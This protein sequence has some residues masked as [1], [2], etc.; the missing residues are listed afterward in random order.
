MDMTYT[1]RCACGAVSATITGEPARVGQCWC[2]QCQKSAAGSPTSNAIF[3][4]SD[5]TVVGALGRYTYEADSGNTVYQDFC[6]KCGSAVLGSTKA[7]PQFVGFRLGFLDPD[8]GLKPTIALW[9]SEAPD[10]A[11]IDP[12]L[13][14]YERQPPPPQSR[15]D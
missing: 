5:V 6:P 15:P 8:H 13:E 1:G 4:V 9:T 14:Q 10:W 11:V 2:S 12:S 7:R 3:D